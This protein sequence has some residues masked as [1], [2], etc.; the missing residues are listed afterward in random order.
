MNVELLHKEVQY[1]AVASS[2][3]GGQN[4]N[5]VATKVQL[6]FDVL[7]SLAFAKAEQERIINKLQNQLT[8]E[9]FVI[10]GCQESRSQAKNKELA[11]KKLINLLS[12]AAQKPKIRK[13]RTIPKAVK[14]KRLNDKKKQSEKKKDR[15]F[16]Y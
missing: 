10:I 4:V 16:K 13:K 8:K 1:K 12:Q 9:G 11:F 2:G 5:K 7:N 15:N 14:R 3:P 6:Y